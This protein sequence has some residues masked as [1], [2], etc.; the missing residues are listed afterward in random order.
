MAMYSL[1][2]FLSSLDPLICNLKTLGT[3]QEELIKVHLAS[4]YLGTPN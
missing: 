3:L 2:W 1:A 4:G